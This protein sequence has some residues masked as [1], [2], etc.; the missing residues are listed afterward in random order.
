MR[1]PVN[2]THTAEAGIGAQHTRSGLCAPDR[3]RPCR[4]VSERSRTPQQQHHSV[5]SALSTKASTSWS[6]VNVG[7]VAESSGHI[8]KSLAVARIVKLYATVQR[9]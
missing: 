4:A 1:K 8:K 6:S 7:W 3:T 9:L 5:R 2:V